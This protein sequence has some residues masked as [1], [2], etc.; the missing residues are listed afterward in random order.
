[1]DPMINNPR[2]NPAY[3]VLYESFW[4]LSRSPGQ[5]VGG[6]GAWRVSD[7]G[8]IGRYFH[9]TVTVTVA[10]LRPY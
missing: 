7:P 4:D 8:R 2:L 9:G 6:G 3:Y 5:H 10:E 1:M